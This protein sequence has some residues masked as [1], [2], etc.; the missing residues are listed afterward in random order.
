MKP[1]FDSTSVSSVSSVV[2]GS[3]QSEYEKRLAAWS[4]I[5][6]HLPF[7]YEHAAKSKSV[8]ELGVRS[9]I[10]T[11]ALLAGVE[12][13]G[14]N[15]WSVDIEKPR[16]PEWWFVSPI[17]GLTIGDDLD[18]EVARLQPDKID[19]LFIDTTHFYEQTMAE[20][21]VYVPR[22][23]PGGIACCHDTEL[24]AL[25]GYPEGYESFMVAKA[26]EAFCAET[27]LKWENRT[28]SYGLGVIRI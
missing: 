10:S 19:M 1:P 27:G 23:N 3:F 20:L 13:S 21:R 9:G 4:D 17:W 6:E 25:P 14:G 22:V 7:L 5:Q 11:A 26:L 12:R 18:P 8:L 15:L 16:V 2:L 24:P 28:G